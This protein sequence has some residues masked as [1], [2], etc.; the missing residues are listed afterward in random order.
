MKQPAVYIMSNQRNGTLYTG[1]TSNLTK[2][3]YEH[4][5]QLVDGFTKR[6]GRKLLV[7]YEIHKYIEL[8]IM[9]EKQIKSG[10]RKNKLKLIEASNPEWKDLYE[11]NI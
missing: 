9:K 11:E 4:K 8:A 5:H 10:F 7:F 2:R 6:Y 3:V 1:I